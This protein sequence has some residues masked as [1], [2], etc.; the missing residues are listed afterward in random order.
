MK[1]ILLTLA[2]IAAAPLLAAQNDRLLQLVKDGMQP[3][4]LT[5]A[6]LT[7]DG[8]AFLLG[9]AERAQFFLI[10]ESHGNVET[11]RLTVPTIGWIFANRIAS[12]SSN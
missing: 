12:L 8:A 2:A 10:G 7:G 11:C 4:E 1:P 9:E 5:D 3:V 6:G